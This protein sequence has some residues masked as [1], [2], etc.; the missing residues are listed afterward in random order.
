MFNEI[1]Y[2]QS[3]TLGATFWILYTTA[4]MLQYVQK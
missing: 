4:F 2:S 3:D 1:N